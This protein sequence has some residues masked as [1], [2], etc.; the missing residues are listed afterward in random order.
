MRTFPICTKR[1]TPY[2]HCTFKAV[3]F[4]RLLALRSVS[5]VAAP[6][7]ASQRELSRTPPPPPSYLEG[8]K[9]CKDEKVSNDS[10]GILCSGIK[11]FFSFQETT[12]FKLQ[13]VERGLEELDVILEP[14]QNMVLGKE[15]E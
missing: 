1:L 11:V 14:A 12:L 6:L 3:L 8:K 4:E 9:R 15:L 13:A 7:L 2:L 10:N 5:A